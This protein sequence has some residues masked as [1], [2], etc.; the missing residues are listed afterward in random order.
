VSKHRPTYAAGSPTTRR[1]L[2]QDRERG[3]CLGVCAGLAEFFGFDLTLVRVITAVGAF[4]F[5]PTVLIG[6]IVLALLL[7]KKPPGP[8]G[9]SDYNSLSLRRRVRAA[10]HATLDNVRYRFGELD[11]RLQ[12][13]EKYLT[14]R[15][16]ELDQEFETLKD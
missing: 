9:D 2:C 12:R 13:L 5:F 3:V 1:R 4:L 16:F 6:Y 8:E 10:P 14:S 7:P 15:R 11:T